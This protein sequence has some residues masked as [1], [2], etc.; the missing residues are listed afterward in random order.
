[1]ASR[2]AEGIRLGNGLRFACDDLFSET[3]ADREAQLIISNPVT[4]ETNSIF[5]KASLNLSAGQRIAGCYVLEHLLDVGGDHLI[6]VAQDEVLGKQVSLHFLPEVVTRDTVAIE[7]LRHEVK[8]SRALIHPGV[9][10]VYDLLESAEFTAVAMETFEARCL[11]AVL[12]EKGRFEIEELEPWLDQ[13]CV[14]LEEAHRIRLTHRDLAPEN[15]FVTAS[16]RLLIAN[17]GISRVVQDAL[18][19]AGGDQGRIARLYNLSPQLLGG[20]PPSATDDVYGVGSLFYELLGGQPVFSGGDVGGKITRDEPVRLSEL[21]V[22]AGDRG[23]RIPASWENVIAACLNKRSVDR[24]LRPS[25]IVSAIEAYGPV[26]EPRSNE[27]QVQNPAAREAVLDPEP[28]RVDLVEENQETEIPEE[29]AVISR[30]LEPAIL[31]EDAA[32]AEVPGAVEEPAV[33]EEP[34]VVEVEGALDVGVTRESMKTEPGAPFEPAASDRVERE[35]PR[36][37]P[38]LEVGEAIESEPVSDTQ[39]QRVEVIPSENAAESPHS[40]SLS[41]SKGASPRSAPQYY[42]TDEDAWSSILPRRFRFPMAVAAAVVL[43]L[44]L[45]NNGF[46]KK[47]HKDAVG[48][49]QAIATS[50]SRERSELTSVKNSVREAAPASE[51]LLGDPALSSPASALPTPYA[52]QKAPVKTELIVAVGP[53][54]KPSLNSVS[55]AVGSPS[56]ASGDKQIAEKVAALERLKLE[57]AT[58]DQAHQ[59]RLKDQQSASA[60][61]AEAQKAID[62]KIKAAGGAKKAAEELLAGRKKREEEQQ[63]AEA[64]ARTAQQL[65]AEKA[66]VAEEAKKALADFE[67]Q[68]REKLL[69]QER[70]ESEIQSLQRTLSDRQKSA[71]EFGKAAAAAEVARQ[72]RIAAIQQAEREIAEAKA[73]IAKNSAEGERQR[74]AMEAERRKLDDEISTMKA[75]FEQKMKDIEDRRRQIENA[76]AV[77]TTKSADPTKSDIK[78]PPPGTPAPTL[79]L[80][81]SKN[82]PSTVPQ[83]RNP[84]AERTPIAA[85][86]TSA[87]MNSLGMRFAPVGEVSFCVWQTRVKDFETFAKAVNLKSTA[88]RGPGFRQGPDHPVVNVTWTEAIAFCKWLTEKERKEGLIPANQFYRLPYDLEWSTAVALPNESGKTPEARDMGVPDVY[89]WGTEWPP[90]KGAGN[91][92]G[93]ET[94]SDVAIKGY[95]DGFAWTAPV[96]SFPPNKLGLYDMGGNVWQWCMDSWNSESKAKVLRG[97]SWYNGALKLSLLSSCRVHAAPDSST[98]NY[99]FRI[100]RATETIAGRSTKK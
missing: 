20:E 38:I 57:L 7:E 70:M 63:S 93:E 18:R 65:A 67:A 8:R 62:E 47:G 5:S 37:Q 27:L 24:P 73:N 72:Q 92:T 80:M 23:E 13:V 9:L 3:K 2:S 36:A 81:A 90:T 10:R 11:S 100:V 16:G 48:T 84:E 43:A 75:L 21:R 58:T 87:L 64:A 49:T 85:V 76:P 54:P 32:V 15:I 98:D 59:G 82:D 74:Q 1:M 53:T 41:A 34:A 12:A 40:A 35:E 6:W 86:A 17:F 30:S 29:E 28:V 51:K 79:P 68:N 78:L 19:R 33:L 44:F 95:D 39:A 42:D 60:S 22:A 66:R 83:A 31:L 14:T 45:I 50:D 4:T 71:D 56:T 46:F 69:M 91:Y 52:A 94:G 99:G 55:E 26:V 97:A 77:S 88:W 96:G 25:E 61:V 89:P